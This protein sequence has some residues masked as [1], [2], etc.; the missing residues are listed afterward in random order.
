ME[1]LHEEISPLYIKAF[2]NGYLMEQYEPELL[3]ILLTSENR[4]KHDYIKAMAAGRKQYEWEKAYHQIKNIDP[5][6]D[7]DRGFDVEI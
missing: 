6:K 7:K 5:S 4:K 2:N 1:E 3:S